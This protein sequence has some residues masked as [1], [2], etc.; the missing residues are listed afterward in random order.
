MKRRTCRVFDGS[1]QCLALCAHPLLSRGTDLAENMTDGVVCDLDCQDN[2][3]LLGFDACL[4]NLTKM[5][6][7]V[8]DDA[9]AYDLCGA[10]SRPLVRLT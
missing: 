10:A 9:P 1:V 7:V 4:T 6:T 5:A 2:Y 8:F 3:N